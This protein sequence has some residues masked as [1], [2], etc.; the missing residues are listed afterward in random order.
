MLKV[1]IIVCSLC[2]AGT[3]FWIE[4]KSNGGPAASRPITAA[5]MPSLLDLH[6]LAHT[7]RLRDETVKDPF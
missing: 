7:D 3:A 2:A 5:A 1:G 6:L 4:A